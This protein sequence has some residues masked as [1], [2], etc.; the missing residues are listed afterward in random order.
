MMNSSILHLVI[1]MLVG[2]FLAKKFPSAL[3]FIPGM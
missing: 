1:A 3:S 2:Y